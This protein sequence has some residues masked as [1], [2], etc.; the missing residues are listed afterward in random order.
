MSGLDV[1]GLEVAIARNRLEGRLCG[2]EIFL[3]DRKSGVRGGRSRHHFFKAIGNDLPH[4]RSVTNMAQI[5]QKGDFALKRK[6]S[7]A[8]SGF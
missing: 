8:T 4:Q 6:K 2:R 5:A 3:E 1:L 7:E